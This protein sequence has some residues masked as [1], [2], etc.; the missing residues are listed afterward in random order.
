MLVPHEDRAT[1]W[2]PVW[3][4]DERLAAVRIWCRK[5]PFGMFQRHEWRHH[6]GSERAEDWIPSAGNS[7]AHGSEPARA[8]DPFDDVL[9][10]LQRIADGHNDPRSLA[11][12]TLA[13]L[14]AAA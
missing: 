13:K 4:V 2:K 12:E 3:W 5:T 7:W 11:Q 9:A 1:P 10:A 14:K 6:D 8:P